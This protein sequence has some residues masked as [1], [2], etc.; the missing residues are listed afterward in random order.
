MANMVLRFY[1]W[2]QVAVPNSAIETVRKLVILYYLENDT[3][4]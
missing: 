3:C 2:T 1:A 4:R